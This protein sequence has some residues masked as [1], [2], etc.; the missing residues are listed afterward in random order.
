VG[1]SPFKGP[2]QILD[3]GMSKTEQDYA[4]LQSE[5]KSEFPD[6]KIINKSDSTLMK[7]IDVTLKII[8]FGQQ[9]T[10]MTGFITTMGTTVYV[11]AGWDNSPV[12]SRLGVLRHERVHMR[13]ARKHGR[14]LFSLMY[15]MLPAPVLFAACRRKFEQ[16][17]YEESLKAV[18]EYYGD[19]ILLDP[20]FRARMIAHFTSAEYFWT[21]P[22]SK[23]IEKWYDGTVARLVSKPSS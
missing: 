22:W 15:L 5:V 13:Q 18:Q 7:V 10:F 11:N 9:K 6:F 19:R 4:A 1:L 2:D 17:A 23:S 3:I 20:R 8:T 21:W 16:E 14:I 12:E